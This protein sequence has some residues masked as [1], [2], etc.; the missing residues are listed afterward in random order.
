MRAPETKPGPK[1]ESPMRGLTRPSVNWLLVFV[2]VSAVA[3]IAHQSVAAFLA[4]AISLVPLAALIGS[5]TEQLAV[6]VGPQRGGLLN[7]TL[8]NLTELIVGCFLIAAGEFTVVKATL[9]GSIVGN[10]LLVLGASFA[11][12][13]SRHKSMSFSPDAASVHS[14]SLLMAVAGLLIPA[15]LVVSSP[16]V[17]FAQKEVVSAS[18]AIV[19]IVMY[20]A[21]LAFMQITHSHLFHVPAR[22]EVATQSA[23]GALTVLAITAGVVA[24]ESD[25][26]VSSLHPAIGALGIPTVFVGLIL[27]PV[28]GNVA[29]NASAVFFA[30]RNRLDVTIEI[31]FGSSTQVALFV[32]PLLVFISIALGRP[33]DFIFTGFEIA[34]VALATIIVTLVTIDGRTNWLEGVQLLGAYVVIAVTAYFVAA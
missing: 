26:L 14:S 12:G 6:R 3:A 13:G 25:L 8:S 18:V 11:I 17:G 30:L 15:L 1:T 23:A 10:A 21:A 31:A 9:I 22:G 24:F 16:S 7:A 32:A 33:M 34:I 4:S 29:E 2:P 20:L 27:I 19:L 28:V 5:S